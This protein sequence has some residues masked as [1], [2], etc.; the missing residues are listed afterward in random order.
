MY[1]RTAMEGSGDR[2]CCPATKERT[3]A[4]ISCVRLLILARTREGG[5]G[6]PEPDKVRW[7]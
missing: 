1:G 6:L 7:R 5:G 2:C 4:G 3:L